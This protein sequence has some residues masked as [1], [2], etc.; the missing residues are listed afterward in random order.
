MLANSIIILPIYAESAREVHM[1]RSSTS[2]VTLYEM[3]LR[4]ETNTC[5]SLKAFIQQVSF[6]FFVKIYF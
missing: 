3:F 1:L 6:S 4:T 5:G 2:M